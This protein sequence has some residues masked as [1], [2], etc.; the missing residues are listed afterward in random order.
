MWLLA[1]DCAHHWVLLYREAA[2]LGRFA[3]HPRVTERVMPGRSKALWDQ[4]RIPLA[5]RREPL[6]VLFHPKFT[7]PLLAPCPTVMTVHG[8]TGSSRSTRASMAAGMSRISG[9]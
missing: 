2:H 5:A 9:R 8:R 1:L 7:V 6:D 4:V 3:E